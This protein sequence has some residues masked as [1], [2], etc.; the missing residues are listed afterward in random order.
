MAE[1]LNTFL[2]LTAGG[3][4]LVLLLIFLRYVLFRTMPATAYY[5]LWILVLLRF[6][7]PI[8]GVLPVDRPELPRPVPTPYVAPVSTHD[9]DFRIYAR[10]GMF[11]SAGN[12]EVYGSEAGPVQVVTGN[13]NGSAIAD[14][15]RSLPWEELLFALWLAGFVISFA[16]YV[17]GYLRFASL[18]RRS[19]IRPTLDDNRCYQRIKRGRK[20]ELIRSKY[21]RTPMLMGLIRP[22]LVLPDTQYTQEQ[23]ENIF[24]HELMHYRRRDIAYK[25][26]SVPVYSSQWFNPLA[27]LM[28]R[29]VNRACELSCDEMLIARMDR[30]EKQSYG[31]TLISLASAGRL[32]AGIVATTFT[33]EKR[34]LK[35]RLVK[36]MKF[37]E[38]RF[39]SILALVL[40]VA[41][42]AGCGAV[43]GPVKEGKEKPEPE[44]VETAAKV[45][46]AADT[47]TP[48]TTEDGAIIVNNVDEL[49]AAI[50]PG[51]KI[52]LAMGVYNLTEAADYGV[53]SEGKYYSWAEVYDGYELVIP[54]LDGL[55]ITGSYKETTIATEPRYANVIRFVNCKNINLEAMV[56]G[57][58]EKQGFCSGGV[59]YFDSCNDTYI[60]SCHL[61]G[62]GIIGIF[63]QNCKGVYA[64]KCSI[65]ECSQNAVYALSSQDLRIENCD[66][67]DCGE[68][69]VQSVFTVDSSNGFA[70]VNSN[71]F[72]NT[73]L[74][75]IDSRYSQQVSLLGCNVEENV[76]TEPMFWCE[77]YSVT[78]EDCRFDL[79]HYKALYEDGSQPKLP[80]VNS[81]GRELTEKD[82]IEMEQAAASYD[83]PQTA[84]PVKLD[85]TV[86]ADGVRQV[87]VSTVDEFLAAIDDNTVITL[88]APLFDLSTASDYGAY[89][90]E[91]YY[92][93]NVYDG[94]GLVISGVENLSIVGDG[95]VISAI[96][97]YANVLGFVN[98]DNITLRGFTAGHT[99]EPGECVGGVLD[100]QNC[101]G[102]D[103]ADCRLYGCG[104]LGISASGCTKLSVEKTEIYDCSQGAIA[105]Y[106]TDGAAFS[107]CDIHDCRTPEISISGC[108]GVTYNGENLKYGSFQIVDNMAIE[109]EYPKY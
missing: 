64:N 18:I 23:L 42:L 14:T 5:Y 79:N 53:T 3:S 81:E 73:A 43:A 8:P 39:A 38:K 58:T 89:G 88:N 55:S 57:H 75:L 80:P 51:A 33:T 54:G 32:P 62:C 24:L 104:I 108:S 68:G 31:D 102:I 37:K 109:F 84:E 95:A 9:S 48:D 19:R 16:R 27:Y 66:I 49:L 60:D 36:I 71:I 105:L 1:F 44:M 29:E 17:L 78:V 15:L 77:G 107:D 94:P 59:L 28:R 76:F 22:V 98:C 12:V 41:L 45:E 7:L 87:T 92:W 106:D 99:E 93:F 86:D 72:V 21:V 83:G 67:H 103:I 34:D 101:N 13:A 2:A 20:P 10:P 97:R 100:F 69:M 90:N 47:Q 25:W 4:V 30:D 6:A 96:P 74:H 40:S 50:A 11:P 85:E 65:Y 91:N 35:E 82:F 70:V 56:I 61:Y 26:L 52:R 63:A 46:E